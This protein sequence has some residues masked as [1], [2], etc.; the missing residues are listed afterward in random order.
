MDGLL[1]INKPKGLTS[2]DV[3]NKIRKIFNTKQVGHL[4]TLDPLATGVLVVCI[5]GATKLVQ[6][7]ENVR[8]TYICE[9]T[10]GIETDSYDITGEI[11]EQKEIINISKKDIDDAL[12]SFLGKSKQFPPLFSAIKKN[13]KK[14]YEYARNNLEVEVLPRDIEIF[15]IERI[16]E[17]S[18]SNGLAKFSFIVEVSKGTYIR[19]ICH[20]LGKKVSLPATLSELC[21]IKNGNFCLEK[22]FTLEQIESGNYELIT[23]LDAISDFP[24]INSSKLI[25]KAMHGM[26]ISFEDIKNSCNDLPLKIAIVDENKLIAI[27]LKDEEKHCY[28][29]G[30]VW[31]L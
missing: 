15:N 26:K 9:V 27:Y 11:V 5:G 6:F 8:K 2:H 20:D 21:R 17:I 28:K 4:G 16:S 18:I 1:V 7:L 30:R 3:V 25:T 10:L 12:N 14:L 19:S 23:S 31:S 13:G 22:S 29:A 24:S